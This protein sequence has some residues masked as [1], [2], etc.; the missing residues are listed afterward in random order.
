MQRYEQ[1]RVLFKSSLISSQAPSDALKCV[2]GFTN[3]GRSRLYIFTSFLSSLEQDASFISTPLAS[4]LSFGEFTYHCLPQTHR[5]PDVTPVFWVA[6]HSGTHHTPGETI[7]GSSS[8]AAESK[9]RRALSSLTA[10]SQ[11]AGC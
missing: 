8:V 11:I 5:G 10:L 3:Q 7:L 2:H 1:Q 9:C 6:K 4:R